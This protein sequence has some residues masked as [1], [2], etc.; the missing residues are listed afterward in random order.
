MKK[1][2]LTAIA[3]VVLCV[4]GFTT[5][6]AF[7]N[8][9]T[10]SSNELMVKNLEALTQYEGSG[11]GF[12]CSTYPMPLICAGTQDFIVGTGYRSYL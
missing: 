10:L 8:G 3:G 9:N 7:E 11:G 6:K 12:S 2:I 4:A 1:N 5:Y